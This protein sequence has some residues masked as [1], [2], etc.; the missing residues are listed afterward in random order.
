MMASISS[1]TKIA[2]NHNFAM[3]GEIT[4]RGHVTEIGGLKDKLIAAKRGLIDTVLIPE[5]NDKELVE[6]P[7]EIKQGLKIVTLKN[8]KEAIGFAL[9]N[10][11]DFDKNKKIVEEKISW[12]DSTNSSSAL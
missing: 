6:I 11:P 4:L 5:D 2:V 8:V 9:E 1:F 3:T 7:D 10:H 12:S